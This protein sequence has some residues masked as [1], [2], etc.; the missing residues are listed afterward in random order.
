MTKDLRAGTDAG[1]FVLCDADF[2]W[3][4]E[5]PSLP[6]LQPHVL[7]GEALLYS[8]GGDGEVRARLLLDEAMPEEFQPNVRDQQRDLLLKLPS[9]RLFLCGLEDLGAKT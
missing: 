3:R 4:F 5:N 9:G 7:A 1:T 6:A 8:F 2:A